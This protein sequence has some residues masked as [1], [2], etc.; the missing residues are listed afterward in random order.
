MVAPIK[1]EPKHCRGSAILSVVLL[2][3]YKLTIYVYSL[4]M[5]IIPIDDHCGEEVNV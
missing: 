3:L 1:K 2:V 5:K 4:W